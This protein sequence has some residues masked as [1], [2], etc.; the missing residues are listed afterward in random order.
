MHKS[1]S[2]NYLPA[3]EPPHIS[4]R[5]LKGCTDRISQ[6]CQTNRKS[7]WLTLGSVQ[8]ARGVALM[9]E[10]AFLSL[11]REYPSSSSSLFLSSLELRD[12]HVYEP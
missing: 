1:M 6:L 2:L 5:K 4:V 7:T 12:T 9:D 11:C 3:S 8:I 10:A